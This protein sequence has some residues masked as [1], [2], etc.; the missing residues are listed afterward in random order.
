MERPGWAGA[1]PKNDEDGRL[2]VVITD[3]GT[4]RFGEEGGARIVL[5]THFSGY[6]FNTDAQLADL[7]QVALTT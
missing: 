6:G 7:A 5:S 4:F 1:D 2:K 3:I